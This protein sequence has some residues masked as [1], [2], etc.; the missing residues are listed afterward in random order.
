[1]S[2]YVDI[3]CHML[4]GVDDGARDD[5]EMYLMLD[6][7]YSSGT[8]TVCMT[9]HF[10]P[11]YYGMNREASDEAFDRLSR[12]ASEKYPDLR[13]MLGNELNFFFGA[14]EYIVSGDCRTLDGGRRILVDFRFDI[15]FFEIKAALYE[16][17]S[18]GL[19]PIFAHAERYDCIKPPYS[20]LKELKDNGIFIQLNAN[21]V[22][23][24]WGRK[25]QKKAFKIIKMGFADAVAS[26]AH[27]LRERAP[28]LDIADST[29]KKYFGEGTA[30][31]LLQR[32]PEIIL[33]IDL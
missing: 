11:R 9:P 26:D 22:T 24:E 33:G 7:A 2:G 20:S 19:E 32:G 3:H 4:S 30:R 18:Q 1:M 23:G 25:I 13:L 8:R 17:K 15:S 29:L 5:A 12:Y 31:H 21:S 14:D 28:R 27:D 16:L 10:N 6:E